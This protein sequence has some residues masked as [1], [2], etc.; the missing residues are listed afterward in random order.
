MTG[1]PKVEVRQRRM[2]GIQEAEVRL[3]LHAVTAQ[4]Y[5]Q[6]I[7]V[8][9]RVIPADRI[10]PQPTRWRYYDMYLTR[11]QVYD[12]VGELDE[13]AGLMTNETPGGT[14]V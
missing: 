12:L 6:R 2:P 13:R 4:N 9:R 8:A 3:I 10:P 11:D 1:R 7:T 14:P 5:T